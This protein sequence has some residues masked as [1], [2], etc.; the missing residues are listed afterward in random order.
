[1]GMNSRLHNLAMPGHG[2]TAHPLLGARE[3]LI[4]LL[5]SLL[6]G[7]R[8]LL[9]YLIGESILVAG[10][11]GEVVGSELVEFLAESCLGVLE[12]VGHGDEGWCFEVG[13]L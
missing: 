12:C 3:G 9:S 11:R 13:N 8:V 5:G 4:D 10:N 2:G 7:D 6:L 1:M